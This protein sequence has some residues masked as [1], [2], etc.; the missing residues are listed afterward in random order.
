MQQHVG[1]GDARG[2]NKLQDCR[3]RE[4]S[5]VER[6]PFAQRQNHA[7]FRIVLRPAIGMD[8]VVGADFDA[9]ANE[10][11]E[12]LKPDMRVVNYDDRRLLFSNRIGE[13]A[14]VIINGEQA[15][16]S[17]CQM[18]MEIGLAGARLADHKNV[19]G[20]ALQPLQFLVAANQQIG[21]DQT[22]VLWKD[23]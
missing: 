1:P 21:R 22:P 10:P 19:A 2:L 8:R 13:T 18:L 11:F 23:R 16:T 7:E 15:K 3:P 17:I 14:S 12:Q 9:K 20:C 4:K 6:L 5:Q